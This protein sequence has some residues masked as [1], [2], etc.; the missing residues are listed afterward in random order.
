MGKYTTIAGMDVHARSIS[1]RVLNRETGEIAS[2]KFTGCPGAAEVAEWLLEFPGPVHAAYESGCTGFH[3]A[4]GLRALGIDCD[5]I[6]VSTLPRSDKDKKQKCDKLDAKVILHELASELPNY[7][8]VAIPDEQLEGDRELGR[9][10]RDAVRALKAAKQQLLSFLLRQGRVYDEKTPTGRRKKCWTRSFWKWVGG[11]SFETEGMGRALGHYVRKVNRAQEEADAMKAL[12]LE[13]AGQP[14]NR[15]YVEAI[16]RI[17]GVDAAS[18]YV[19]RVEIGEFSRFASGRKV[20]CWLGSVPTNSSSGEGEAHGKVTRAGNSTLRC[21]LVECA[22]SIAMWGDAKKKDPDPAG[23]GAEVSRMAAEASERMHGRYR[24]FTAERKM[25]PNKAK[26]AVVN[27]LVRWIW[28]IGCEVEG[29]LASE[30][31][32]GCR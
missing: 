32:L 1:V 27:E 31:A 24:R 14:R 15:P 19:A 25:H 21:M 7:S 28:A 20:S 18:A 3:L 26:M 11:I 13:A 2:R 6:A 10:W 16:A 29:R 4:R 22:S 30:G 5:V 8:V 23:V 12:V 9:A 17:K